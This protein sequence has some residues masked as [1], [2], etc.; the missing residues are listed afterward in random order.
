MDGTAPI[1]MQAD[2]GISGM[3]WLVILFVAL[4]I[5]GSKLP[6][7]MRGLGGSVKEFKKGM[8]EE[9]VPPAAPA[10]A[11][12]AVTHQAVDPAPHQPPK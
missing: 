10:A 4:L 8:N 1:I 12:P 2:F 6:S 7:L 5:F 3:Q 9:P 11:P